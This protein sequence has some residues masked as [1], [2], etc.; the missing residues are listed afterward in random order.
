M[1][2]NKRKIIFACLFGFFVIIYWMP[3]KPALVGKKIILIKVA[4]NTEERSQGL[5]GVSFLAKNTGM[6]FCFPKEGYPQFWMK[7][8]LIALDIA[9]I[10]MNKKIVDIQQMVLINDEKLRYMPKNKAKY[11][12][13]MNLGWFASNEISIGD[14]LVFWECGY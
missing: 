14:K 1:L 6:L 5:K 2:K 8:T 3:L 11:A 4:D 12:L 7:D 13:E 9:F 10:D